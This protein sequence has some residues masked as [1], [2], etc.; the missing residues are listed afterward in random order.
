MGGRSILGRTASTLALPHS[1][2]QKAYPSRVSSAE[3]YD[4][5]HRNRFTKRI[6]I[7]PPPTA[8]RSPSQNNG[9]SSRYVSFGKAHTGTPW[10]PTGKQA[11]LKS[12]QMS[13]WR[14][15]AASLLY[16]T[17]PYTTVKYH[18]Q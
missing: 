12:E 1:P 8:A 2:P 15:T 16:P 11:H 9:Q 17:P 14:D 7:L 5:P 4:S 13:C 10:K 18:L 3:S 6:V